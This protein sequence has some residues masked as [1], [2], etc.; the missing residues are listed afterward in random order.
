MRAFATVLVAGV[1]ASCTGTAA[2]VRSSDVTPADHTVAVPRLVG[3]S[4][5]EATNVL[6][7]AELRL[8]NVRVVE[9]GWGHR[10]VVEQDPPPGTEVPVGRSVDVVRGWIDVGFDVAGDD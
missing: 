3:L 9:D 7:N 5:H 8:G 2:P 10:A 1:L 6:K 4:L